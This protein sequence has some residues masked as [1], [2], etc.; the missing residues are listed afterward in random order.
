MTKA[1]LMQC[2]EEIAIAEHGGHFTIMR[3]GSN[4]RVSF[5]TPM[6]PYSYDPGDADAEMC[7]G[8]TFEEAAVAAIKTCR[9]ATCITWAYP[10]KVAMDAE[11]DAEMKKYEAMTEEELIDDEIAMVDSYLAEPDTTAEQTSF[12]LERKKELVAERQRLLQ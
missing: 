7:A 1:E 3:F 9:D 12:Y 4:W 8:K 11:L 10:S 2:L 6:E 5:G